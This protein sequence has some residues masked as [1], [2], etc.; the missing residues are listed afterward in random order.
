MEEGFALNKPPMFKGANY[1]Y[2]KERIIAFFESAHIN[3][4][5]VVEKGNHIPLDAQRNEIPRDRW[6]NEHKSRFT[7]L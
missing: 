5:D 2:W 7:F 3:M 6:T 4:W 1:E